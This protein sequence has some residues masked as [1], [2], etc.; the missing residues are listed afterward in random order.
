MAGEPSAVLHSETVAEAVRP[1]TRSKLRPPRLPARLV[2]DARHRAAAPAILAHSVCLVHAPSG[3]GKS[4]LC[5]AWYRLMG[6]LGHAAAWVSFEREDD[7]P[8]RAIGYILQSVAAVLAGAHRDALQVLAD[9]L[10]A[11]DGVIVPQAIATR[12]INTVD[13]FAAPMV[14]F[15]DDIDRLTD[16]RILQFLNYLLLHAPANLH[17]VLACQGQLALP[18]VHL[19]HHGLLL[20]VGVEELRLSDAE[21]GDLLAT[22]GPAL[23]T[24]DVHRLNEAMAGWVTGLRIGSAALRNNRDALFD[25]GLVAHGA[26][27]LSDYLD[28][29]ILQHL[30]PDARAFLTRCAVVETMNAGL[31]AALSGLADAGTML[32]WL[33]D[34]NLFVQR[35]DD[36]GDW[37]RIHAVLPRVPARAAGPRG[38]CGGRPAAQCRQPLVRRPRPPGRGDRPRPRRRR[39]RCR[40]GADRGRGDGDGRALGHPDP[41]RLDRPAAH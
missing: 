29:N 7:D 1:L 33:A 40:R 12:L 36:G 9:G 21:A 30:T 41:A 25:I 8:A 6:E 35:L 18:L 10:S 28:E 17:L 34:Q 38:P 3:Y 27:W 19:D 20:R 23:T 32:G 11:N 39:C 15:L 2:A 5:T 16:P 13:E 4:T 31:C 24:A 37:Y 14:L 26:R 22:G